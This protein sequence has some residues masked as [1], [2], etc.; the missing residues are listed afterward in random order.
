MSTVTGEITVI[1]PAHHKRLGG[2]AFSSLGG[3]P[4]LY[5][6]PS[7]NPQNVYNERDK[8]QKAKCISMQYLVRINW[9]EDNMRVNTP[10]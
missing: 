2:R 4:P 3:K 1:V 10:R 6:S 9:Y 8:E 7:R 5:L